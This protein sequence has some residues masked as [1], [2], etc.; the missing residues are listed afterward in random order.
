MVLKALQKHGAP[1]QQTH[2]PEALDNRGDMCSDAATALDSVISAPW[3]DRFSS[4]R[5]Y[6]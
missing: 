5:S 1:D 2:Q 6:L 4:S 3:H